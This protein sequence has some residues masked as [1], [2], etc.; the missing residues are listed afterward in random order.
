MKSLFVMLALSISSIVSAQ[1]SPT[2]LE[3]NS[4][5]SGIPCES[6]SSEREILLEKIEGNSKTKIGAYRA[7]GCKFTL[8]KKLDFGNYIFTIS[9][10]DIQETAL[11][12][13]V[14]AQNQE[15]IIQNIELKDKTNE[16]SE[17]TVYGNQ[18]QYMKVESDKTII[19]IKENGML[20]SGT[21]LEAIKKLPGVVASPVGGLTLNGKGV[22]V[23]IDGAPSNLTGTDLQ[24]Y[25]N[26]LPANAI[27][28]IELIYDPGAAYD[29]NASGS[30]INIVTNSK[31]MKGVNA[32]FNINYNFN[33][34]QKPS[35]Q[36][37]LNGKKNNLSWQTMFGVNY[38]ERENRNKNGQEFTYFN[39]PVKLQQENFETMIFR[40]VYWRT[41]LNYKLSDKSNILFNYN[42][43]LS[44]DSN[45]N[46]STAFGNTIDFSNHGIAKTKANNQELSLQF[47]TKL[48]TLGR[49]L[50]V[51]AYTNMFD[52]NPLN[53]STSFENN[54]YT[55]NNSDIDFG[56]TNYYLKY[57]FS[58][59]FEKYAF[60][61]NTGGKYN[62]T[63]VKDLGKYNFEED[64]DAIFNSNIYESVIDFDYT[65]HNLAFYVEARKK[66]KKFNFTAGLR[67]ENFE[68][69][70]EAST[71]ADKIK[72][73]NNRFFPNASILFEATENIN[74]ST[75]YSKKISQPGYFT[76][77]PNNG[78]N[79]NRYNTST[80]NI[81]LQPIFFDNY[82]FKITAFQYVSLSTNYA[83]AKNDTQ[84]IFSAKDGELVSN[85]TFAAFDKI[86]TFST[87]LSF[88]IPLDYFFKSREEFSKRLNEIDKMNYIYANI[89][90]IKTDIE[91]YD[92]TFK[93]KGMVNF[94]LEAQT[95][96]PWGI[97]NNMSYFFLPKGNWE[98][99]RIEK[100]IQQFDISFNKAFLDKKLKVGLHCFDVFNANEVNALVEGKNLRTLFYEKNDS[101]TFRISLTY[102]FG[103]QKLQTEN[104]NIQVEKAN[105]GGKGL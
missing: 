54:K 38:I 32:S 19:S 87:S 47:K 21:T 99:Y 64:S 43:S 16:L 3:L 18:R 55:Y 90:Y 23:Y 4:P 1:Q 41:G 71:V 31:K 86:K 26:S 6:D 70:R 53:R 83:V 40:N 88:P 72:F 35:P 76:I 80:G 45:D 79:F 104:T 67:F 33:K 105:E 11:P 75:S 20:N 28:K 8:T 5:K 59:P 49:T 74:L 101:R 98:I 27:E 2:Y 82:G 44:N 25:L 68:I 13:E 57:D 63:K 52:R 92:F 94:S 34:Y 14:T 10:L 29:A 65:E 89:N 73:N 30:I 69:E 103:N 95:H 61:I 102:N 51:I 91:G 85:R 46:T 100:P 62:T 93:N 56:L 36:I 97:T 39:P 84:F 96:L 60:T 81:A 50:D 15:K 78:S 48:D 9:G 37:L 24:N 12:F 7:N 77:D 58:F 17:V 66:Y 42:M 22:T